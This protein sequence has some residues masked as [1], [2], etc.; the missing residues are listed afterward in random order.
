MT[1]TPEFLSEGGELGA[2]MRAK[3]WNDTPLGASTGWPEALKHTLRVILASRQPMLIWWGTALYQF[4]NDA[5]RDIVGPE[6]HPVMLGLSGRQTWSEEWFEVGPQVD[7]IMAGGAATWHQNQRI[8]VMR[9]GAREDVWWDYGYSPIRD[10]RGVRGVLVICSDVSAGQRA[11]AALGTLN[12]RCMAEIARR[13]QSEQNQKLQLQIADTLRGLTESD[14]IAKA[15]FHLLS[16][17]L[18][19]SQIDYAEVDSG[20]GLFVI[21]HSW[22][23]DR[24]PSLCRVGGEI[25]GYGPAVIDALR[26][27][28][29]VTIADVQTDPRTAAH[30]AVYASLRTRACMIVPVMK[31]GALAAILTLHQ[32]APCQWSPGH[33]ALVCD[34]AERIWHAMEHADA[35]DRQREAE[36]A[37]TLQRRDENQRLRSLFYQAPGFMVILC[38]PQHVYEFVNAAYMNVVGER[39]L[40]GL[41]VREALPEVEGQGFFELLDE[42]Y[43]TA[44]PRAAHDVPLVVQAHAGAPARRTY[45]DFVYQPIVDAAGAVTGIFVEGSDTTERHLAKDALDVSR[46]RL[47]EGMVAARMAIWDWDLATE[48]IIFSQNTSEV[49]GGTWASIAD[50]WK[51]VCEGDL[52]RLTLAGE[53]AEATCGSY[54]EVVRIKRA[55]C[56]DPL[57]L[58]IH[59]K[60]IADESGVV[61]SVRSVAIDVS[62]LKYALKALQDAH[63]RKDEFLAMLAH[64]LRNPLAPIRAAAQLLDMVYGDGNQVQRMGAVNA[65]RADHMT[66]LIN[67]LLDVSPVTSGLVTL[68]KSAHDIWS[69]VGKSVEQLRPMM[70]ERFPR[71]SI[72]NAKAP[73]IVMGERKRLVQV[74]TNLLQNAAKYTP[75]KGHI[76]REVRME[77]GEVGAGHPRQRRGDDRRTAAACV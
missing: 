3:A 62:G 77:G 10:D 5:Y 24:V 32:S 57:W 46:E 73:M 2:L 25:D 51:A 34:I 68:D 54:E 52:E 13:E 48:Q 67:D 33:I 71:L 28:D 45:V 43:A 58:Q 53:A 47:G 31:G 55:G 42:A 16:G 66:S 17:F 74:V 44:T 41:T 6:R 30:V 75:P 4:Y 35:Q 65:R 39:P 50:V 27:A 7:S 1:S 76:Q 56:D 59:G 9:D 19:V 12:L 23:L 37:L 21:R 8:F 36:Q 38:G 26:A 15:A 11:K 20:G 22:E 49:F 69:I 63:V 14:A 29:V 40:L 64:Q 18:P 70:Q 72:D 60:F 61:R